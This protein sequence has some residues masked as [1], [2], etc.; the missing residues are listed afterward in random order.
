MV[1][2]LVVI[3]GEI[4]YGRWGCVD[5]GFG[6]EA[7]FV[8]VGVIEVVETWRHGDVEMEALCVWRW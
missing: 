5:G 4:G 2:Q 6:S 8:R 1:G 7:V 3:V